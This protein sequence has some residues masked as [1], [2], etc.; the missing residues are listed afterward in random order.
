MAR[1]GAVLNDV[2]AFASFAVDDLEKARRF[3]RDTLGLTIK[4]Q[5]YGGFEMDVGQGNSIMVY[6][7]ADHT[8]ATFTVLNFP[9]DDIEDTMKRLRDGGIRFETY[10]RPDLRTDAQGIAHWEGGP[11]MAWFKDPAGNILSV[12]TE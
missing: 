12:L 2:K 9:V 5:E 6:E 7:K 3:Y 1:H 8:P 10:D 11:T 4:D